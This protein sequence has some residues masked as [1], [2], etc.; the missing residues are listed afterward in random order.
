RFAA[1]PGTYTRSTGPSPTV[2]NPIAN[3]PL[4]VKR[5]GDALTT[6]SWSVG[7][8][9]CNRSRQGLADPKEVPHGRSCSPGVYLHG[10][11]R[12]STPE[13][14]CGAARSPAR[15][16]RT[17]AMTWSLP[18][19]LVDDGQHTFLTHRL[20]LYEAEW[21]GSGRVRE[22]PLAGPEDD[23]EHHQA[24][25]IDEIVGG[26]RLHQAG[27]AVDHDVAAV[28]LLELAH[29]LDNV[30][31]EQV[32]VV[33]LQR[34][35]ERRGDD[36]LG[37]AVEPVG[38]PLLVRP[39]G[40][41]SSEPL[42]GH[43]AEQQRVACHQL[44]ELEPVAVLAAVELERPTIAR[45]ARVHAGTLHHTVG[46]HEFRHHEPS[47][48]IPP[49]S[50]ARST[51][52]GGP[53]LARP[54]RARCRGPS[55]SRW[56]RGVRTSGSSP[57]S[58]DQGGRGPSSLGIVVVGSDRTAAPI[59]SVSAG[60]SGRSIP[61]PPRTGPASAMSYSGGAF[62]TSRSRWRRPW[63]RPEAVAWPTPRPPSRSCSP[64]H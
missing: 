26:K 63:P 42:V 5:M 60:P 34:L 12:L 9:R 27:A 41:R 29:L 1:Q 2:W 13:L 7:A 35:T 53:T 59:S 36:V 21:H 37:H 28:L 8:R 33:P 16:I 20:G 19:S 24:V 56:A 6:T 57:G 64:P 25:D 17:P 44:V 54:A 45:S 32:R 62:G 55:A 23:R 4:H 58:V 50:P 18:R 15:R 51:R 38:E 48:V 31:V 11:E 39:S 43:P 52:G 40:P 22:Q 61:H 30:A 47:H 14:S 3:S 49:C 46:G 10:R